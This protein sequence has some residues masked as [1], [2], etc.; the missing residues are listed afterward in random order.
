[1]AKRK[2]RTI[3]KAKLAFSR[4]DPKE[5]AEAIARGETMACLVLAETLKGRL[6]K[7]GDPA[8]D[9]EANVNADTA[10]EI[11]SC[12]VEGDVL[13]DPEV[14]GFFRRLLDDH[15]EKIARIH[16]LGADRL[17]D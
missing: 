12:L 5:R 16:A 11:L 1:M 7:D 2:T 8:D 10:E 15:R 17:R 14:Q 6:L 9:V 13:D 3:D 4:L